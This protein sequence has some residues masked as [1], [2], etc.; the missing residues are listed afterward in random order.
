MPSL[1]SATVPGLTEKSFFGS[2]YVNFFGE[3][4]YIN[5][6]KKKKKVP[7]HNDGVYEIFGG[8][9]NRISAWSSYCTLVILVSDTRHNFSFISSLLNWILKKNYD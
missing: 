3:A 9:G 5:I 4:I 2:H 6:K 8:H 1:F 7:T